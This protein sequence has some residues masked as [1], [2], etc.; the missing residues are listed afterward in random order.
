[1][2]EP[3]PDPQTHSNAEAQRDR[4][5]PVQASK[6]IYREYAE[7]LAVAAILALIIRTFLLQAYKIPS[8]SMEPTLLIGDHILVNKVAYGLRM[9]DSIFG[10]QFPGLSLGRYVVRFG[11]IHRG[12]VIVFVFPKDRSKD[13]IKRVIALAGDKVEVR[14]TQ[15]YINDHKIA[16]SHAH[17]SRLSSNSPMSAARLYGDFG[18]EVV[19]PG[20]IFVMGDNRDQ[21][22]DSRFWG[23]VDVNDVEGRAV[24]IYWSWDD[25]AQGLPK[26]RWSRIGKLIE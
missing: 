18:P 10:F 12:D 25:D 9:P 17:Y 2:G 22:Y 26:V 8:G 20:K 5:R 7:A 3:V 19:P 15:V 11:S 24:I 14:G 6:S 13:F 21:S 1:M 16:D 4:A 23:F